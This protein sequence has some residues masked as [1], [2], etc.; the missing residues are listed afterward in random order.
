MKTITNPKI[1]KAKVEIAKTK[2][3]IAE[4][5][6]KLR[7]QERHLKDLEDLE[8]VARFRKEIF[9]DNDYAAIDELHSNTPVKQKNEHEEDLSD[10]I[11]QH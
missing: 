6:T 2:A 5:Q 4:I 3:K 1:E 10:D 11:T 9:S 7:G 8:I